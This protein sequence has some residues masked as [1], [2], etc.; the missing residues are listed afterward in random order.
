MPTSG[1]SNILR[2]AKKAQEY[3]HVNLIPHVWQNQLGLIMSMHA[4]KVQKNIPFVEDS[5]FFEHAFITNDYI[6]SNGQW[7]IP[8]KPGWGIEFSADYIQY[9][10]GKETILT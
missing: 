7:F 4:S 10:V 5:R 1:M 8:D 2:T 9:M 6:F 3:S